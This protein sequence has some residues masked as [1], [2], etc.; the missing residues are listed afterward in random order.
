MCT[1]IIPLNRGPQN[2]TY[3]IR[4]VID[5]S[6]KRIIGGAFKVFT[7]DFHQTVIPNIQ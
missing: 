3:Y 1:R 4:I 5:Q 7:S 2:G 6:R